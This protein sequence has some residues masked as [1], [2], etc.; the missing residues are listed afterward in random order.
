MK[1]IN[2]RNQLNRSTRYVVNSDLKQYDKWINTYNKAISSPNT[3]IYDIF[4]SYQQYLQS[5][6]TP[7]SSIARKLSN[8]KNFHV[9]FVNFVKRKRLTSITSKNKEILDSEVLTQKKS[10]FVTPQVINNNIPI[11]NINVTEK[12]NAQSIFGKNNINKKIIY[13]LSI[14]LFLAILFSYFYFSGKDGTT[15]V[16]VN[17][18]LELANSN[19][20]L[21]N[22][23]KI[24]LSLSVKNN[25]KKDETVKVIYLTIYNSRTSR[26]PISKSSCSFNVTNANDEDILMV[27]LNKYCSKSFLSNFSVNNFLGIRVNSNPESY[28]RL[29]IGDL[30]NPSFYSYFDD[31]N[32]NS[33][34]TQNNIVKSLRSKL[35]SS[36][37]DKVK[38]TPI[39]DQ[40]SPTS[41]ASQSATISASLIVLTLTPSPTP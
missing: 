27:D 23:Q 30:L 11:T 26:S 39:F 16:S 17:P 13:F 28:P 15:K 2:E 6:N 38:I 41:I 36:F 9:D 37:N 3:D 14:T 20:S 34:D 19:P 32:T 5:I 40:L 24:I 22:K 10:S 18:L 33:D 7:K 29:S 8:I 35:L 4:K 21:L 25:L 1:L 31:S 12:Y